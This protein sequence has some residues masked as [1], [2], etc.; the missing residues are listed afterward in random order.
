L[1][2]RPSR[3]DT[4]IISDILLEDSNGNG[5][6]PLHVEDRLT[7]KLSFRLRFCFL[8]R[9][10]VHACKDKLAPSILPAKLHKNIWA[11]IHGQTDNTRVHMMTMLS[12]QVLVQ[13]STRSF[14]SLTTDESSTSEKRRADCSRQSRNEHNGSVEL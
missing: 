11:V 4:D 3:T 8:E 5:P 6:V 14:T 13:A 10:Y 7:C 1:L 9:P 2:G 12:Y